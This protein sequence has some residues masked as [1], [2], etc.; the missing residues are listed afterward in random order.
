MLLDNETNLSRAKCGDHSIFLLFAIAESIQAYYHQ[1]C[2]FMSPQFS[3]PATT[4]PP[5]VPPS[6][7]AQKHHRNG[8]THP[9]PLWCRLHNHVN[10]L[11]KTAPPQLP[12]LSHSV[13]PI[14]AQVTAGKFQ[15]PA[16]FIGRIIRPTY[17]TSLLQLDSSMSSAAKHHTWDMHSSNCISP[18]TIVERMGWPSVSLKDQ[19]SCV[20]LKQAMIANAM[21][22]VRT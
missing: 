5:A 19:R 6:N 4:L 20:G 17:G 12:S 9:Q 22:W 7:H 15:D 13:T 18:P 21:V 14:S 16:P 1:N 2:L 8:L 11:F 10:F 3:P